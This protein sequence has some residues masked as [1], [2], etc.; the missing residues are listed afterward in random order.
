MK[1]F[2]KRCIVY[3]LN[4]HLVF[5][6]IFEFVQA[7]TY[8][9]FFPIKIIHKGI[10]WR[11]RLNSGYC[12]VNGQYFNIS[13][14]MKNIKDYLI[15]LESFSYISIMHHWYF[16]AKNMYLIHSQWCKCYVIFNFIKEYF[17]IIFQNLFSVSVKHCLLIPLI[18]PY[19]Y[20]VLN[21]FSLF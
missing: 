21:N 10:K 7:N 9:C 17:Y 4:F 12:L 2:R 11:H 6:A 1:A 16:N 14:K 20:F 3:L 19:S 13:Y 8:N 15:I 5:L 18:F